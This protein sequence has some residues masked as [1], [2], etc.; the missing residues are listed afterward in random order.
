MWGGNGAVV[1][2][3]LWSNHICAQTLEKGK[4]GLP[5]IVSII[6]ADYEGS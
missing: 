2:V 4:R 6:F 3:A 1:V 5:P